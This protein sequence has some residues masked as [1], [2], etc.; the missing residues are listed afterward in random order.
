M[1]LDKETPY[2][3]SAR[4][5]KTVPKDRTQYSRKS[6]ASKIAL[7]VLL[8]LTAG[9]LGGRLGD[10]STNSAANQSTQVRQQ[11]VSSES[12][13]INEI[14]KNTGPSVV[15]VN[16][17]GSAVQNIF[18]QSI[19]QQ[20]AGTGVIIDE[21]GIIITNRHVVPAGSDAVTV[22][23]SDGTTLKDVEVIG[24]TSSNDPLDVAFLKITDKKGKTL[25]AAKLADS[26]KVQVGDKVVA[27][28]NALGQFQNTVTS[29]I[30]SGFGRSVEAGDESG[31][32]TESLQNLFQTDTA[33][34]QGNSGGPLVNTSGEVIGINTAVAGNA[35][36]IGFAIPINDIQGLIKSVLKEGKLVR[37]YLGVRYITL[38]D[39]IA[40]EYNLSTKRGAYL[41]PSQGQSVIVSGSPAEK[42]GLQE[43]DVITKIE[44]VAIDENNSLTSVLGR[45]AVGDKVTLTVI[46]D[47]KE[48]KIGVTL[49]AAPTQ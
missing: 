18:G 23:L 19:Q 44:N 43:K 25:T 35:E 11:I 45:H 21:K 1:D 32:N 5:T 31:R 28:G 37:P 33:I 10:L 14:A 41:A 34:N 36:N 7:L 15:S 8:C 9:F 16:V 46:R 49:E 29:G 2:N 42:A 39:D 38:T 20:S 6:G 12:Q 22:T 40:Y 13:L 17:T 4:P 47:G 30:I 48:Q 24:R 27:I 26:S 3:I